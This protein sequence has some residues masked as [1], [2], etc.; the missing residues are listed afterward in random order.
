MRPK[1]A[2]IGAGNVG[3]TTALLMAQKELGDIVLYDIVEDMPVGKA[4]DMAEMAP[5][6]GFDVKVEGTNNIADIEGADLAVVTAGLARKPGMSR[7]DL[8]EK[9]AEIVKEVSEKIAQHAPNSIVIMVTN[10]LDVMTYLC[11]KITGFPPERVVGQAGILDTARFRCF[12]AME[13]GVSVKDIQTMVLGGHGDE[14]VPLVSHTTVSGIPLRDL[15]PEERIQAMVERTRMGGGEIV[16]LLKTGSAYYAPGAAVAQMAEAILRD[17]K[18]IVPASAYLTGQYGLEDVY[19]G[20]PVKLGAKGVEEIL[21]L[22]L[23]E[24]ELAALQAS[25]RQYKESLQHLA[26]MWGGA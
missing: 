5:I 14:M 4:L 24:E 16:K 8:L 20:V 26:P 13:L 17:Q 23:P 9:N 1:I 21:E 10:P 6:E 2:V 11:W 19:C 25:A 18:R 15:V 7:M 3:A 22:E 12:I